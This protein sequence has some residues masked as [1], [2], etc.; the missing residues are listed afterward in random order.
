MLYLADRNFL[1]LPTFFGDR[2]PLL[3]VERPRRS[4]HA[5][6]QAKKRAPRYRRL[7][8]HDVAGSHSVMLV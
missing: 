3:K 5:I 4:M 8:V 1:G 7:F 6:G 2:F